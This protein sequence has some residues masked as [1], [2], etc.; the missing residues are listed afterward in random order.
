MSYTYKVQKVL[1][2]NKICCTDP[3]QL[4]PDF[5]LNAA[6]FQVN[7]ATAFLPSS[8]Q[9]NH[10]AFELSYTS[11]TELIQ[12]T[13]V[14]GNVNLNSSCGAF[15]QIPVDITLKAKATC[16]QYPFIKSATYNASTKTVDL[17]IN[18]LSSN[19]EVKGFVL[20]F[21]QKNSTSPYTTLLGTDTTTDPN[22][23]DFTYDL[24][25]LPTPPTTNNVIVE[26]Q[27]YCQSGPDVLSQPS[28]FLVIEQPNSAIP[29]TTVVQGD[30]YN[31][32]C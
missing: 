15:T 26:I 6:G 2:L 25:T 1:K 11:D 18:S 19:P 22:Q 9:T 8:L 32:N 30:C 13:Q 17:T 31:F 24:T 20:T 28:Q 12:D 7:D 23:T 14:V 4:T 5:N 27:S 16:C 21:Y 10:L 29:S 3:I